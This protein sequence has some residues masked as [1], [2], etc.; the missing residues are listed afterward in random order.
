MTNRYRNANHT[1]KNTPLSL[2]SLHSAREVKDYRGKWFPV[3][4][5]NKVTVTVKNGHADW[6]GE[7]TEKIALNAIEDYR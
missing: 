7:H 5:F 3:V 6:S 1:S 2:A 4:K